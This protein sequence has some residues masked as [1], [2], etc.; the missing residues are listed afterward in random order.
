MLQSQ[1]V[2]MQGLAAHSCRLRTSVQFVSKQWVSNQGQVDTD[3]V[4]SAGTQTTTQQA[5]LGAL[6]QQ[7]NSGL[8]GFSGVACQVHN[9]HAQA[10]TRV[11][12]DGRINFPG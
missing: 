4:G 1:P 3:L 2:G 12:P 9:R 7:L 6:L 11:A 8:R 5:T 10:V